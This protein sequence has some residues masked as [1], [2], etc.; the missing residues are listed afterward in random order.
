ML[1][2]PVIILALLFVGATVFGAWAFTSRSDYKNNSDTKAAIAVATAK[3]ATQASDAKLFAEEAKKP[4]TTYVGPDAYGS[5]KVQ[6]PKIWS[7]YVDTTNVS[8]PL[9]A[10]FH[11]DYVPSINSKSTYN[12]RVEVVARS[13]SAQMS[14]Y[15]ALVKS[16]KATAAPYAFPKVPSVTGTILTGTVFPDNITGSGTTILVPLRDKT[17]RVSM[18]SPSYAPD[19]N[20]YILPNLSFSP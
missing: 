9:D 4:L 2:V 5:V 20:T 7:A 17:L 19:F 18:E 15:G 13:Y 1:L 3:Q 10:Y 14:Q 11:T 8:R 16:G 6:Y 12:L